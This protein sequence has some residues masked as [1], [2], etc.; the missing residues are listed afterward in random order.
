MAI[1]DIYSMPERI[2]QIRAAQDDLKQSVAACKL[3]QKAF[4]KMQGLENYVEFDTAWDE[5]KDNL[6]I[7]SSYVEA[8]VA[9]LNV[10]RSPNTGFV[11]QYQWVVGRGG[12]DGLSFS[13]SVSEIG[14]QNNVLTGEGAFADS[15]GPVLLEGDRVIVEGTAS[16]DGIH[17]VTSGGDANKIVVST[18]L[19]TET[20]TSAGA[21][22][23][24]IR[25]GIA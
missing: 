24:L 20:C 22:L 13:N 4:S 17:P 5:V 7:A 10:L 2:R 9:K 21:K 18:T 25:R 16:N 1:T 14:V 19:T 11:F 15:S 12:V 6:D 23:T 3:S 8:A